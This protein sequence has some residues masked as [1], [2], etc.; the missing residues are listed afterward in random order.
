MKVFLIGGAGFIGS[1][2]SRLLLA[3]GHEPIIFDAFL[4]YIDPFSNNYQNTLNM[5]FEGIK[6]KVKI[7]RGDIRYKGHL[8]KSLR[9]NKP[10]IV[11]HLAALPIAAKSNEFPEDAS[12]IN[13]TG[14]VNVLEAVR[15]LN[16]IER[17]IF[18]SS[19]FT[20]GNFQYEPA[21]EMHPSNP[22]DV[23]G[24]T[25]LCGEILTRVYAK[26]YGVD[27]TIIR[28]SAVYGPGDINKRVVQAFVEKAL[29]NEPLTL[30]EGGE[31][32][33]DFTYVSDAAKGFVLAIN[34]KKA[35]NETFNITAGKARE[36]KELVEIIKENLGN[37]KIEVK[38]S[39]TKRPTRGSLDITK[40]RKLLGYN[41]TIQLEEGI[42]KYLQGIK[43]NKIIL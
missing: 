38:P 41:P 7:I 15:E 24:G 25:K 30:F 1:Y 35:K 31:G 20:Y 9:E 43:E 18:T 3:E 10:D 14:T 36:I 28:P 29:R 22:I 23:Y 6:D 33:V 34:S 17:V 16:D 2:L 40:A 39:D 13:L 11:V 32:K 19:S 26:S 4:N 12:A 27:Y 5:R 37:V 42:K 8:L 21:D